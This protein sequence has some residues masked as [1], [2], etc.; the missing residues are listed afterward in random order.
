MFAPSFLPFAMLAQHCPPDAGLMPA[1]RLRRWTN[2]KHTLG[3][4]IV[5]DKIASHLTWKWQYSCYL[6]LGPASY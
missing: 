3:Q 5:L 2:I 1:H 6:L 4:D